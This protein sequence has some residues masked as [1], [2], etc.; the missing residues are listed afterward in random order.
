VIRV[1]I[2]DDEPLAREG[3][4]LRLE[5][6]PGI[7]VVAE[8]GSGSA[9][10]ATILSERPD[11]VFLD[12]QMPGGDG[13]QVLDRVAGQHLPEVVFVTAHDRHAVRA[14]EVH[15]LDYLLKPIV[16]ERFEAALRRAR[17]ELERGVA[18]ANPARLS[19]LL[20]DLR[21]P[22]AAGASPLRR[23]A[24]RDRDRFRLIAVEEVRWFAAAGNYVEVH[25]A[26]GTH[27]IRDGIAALERRLDPGRFARIHRSTIVRLDGVR[28]IVP[29]PH[30]DF[31]VV[32]DDGTRLG[33]SRTHRSRLL[34]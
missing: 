1:V 7:T 34:P 11:L 15:A 3:L 22:D 18:R 19:D 32:L 23:F 31:E 30:G 2:V 14:F 16:D 4:R 33:M 25:T 28:E 5:R 13:F 20:D 12:V 24:V 26:A 29:T 6:E 27:L 9:A 17:A 21:R 8:A 10:V